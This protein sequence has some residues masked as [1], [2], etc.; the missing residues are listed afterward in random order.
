M[1]SSAWNV[2]RLALAC[3]SGGTE[4]P[5]GAKFCKE[6]G[7]PVEP[8][9]SATPERPVPASYISKHLAERIITATK[10][11]STR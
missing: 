3:T 9:S 5:A 7:E 6:C 1:P 4:L 2:R 11:P 8:R 10:G